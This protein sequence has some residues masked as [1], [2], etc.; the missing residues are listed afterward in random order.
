MKVISTLL[1]LVVW[2]GCA[3][4]WCMNIYKLVSGLDVITT[5]EAVVRSIG[6]FAAPLGAVAGYF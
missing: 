1:F 6:V 5:T 2:L 4:G 3:I